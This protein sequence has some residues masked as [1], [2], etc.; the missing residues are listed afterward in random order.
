M[1]TQTGISVNL[2]TGVSFYVAVKAYR[3]LAAAVIPILGIFL[4]NKKNQPRLI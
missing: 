4:Y 2:L 1:G 3:A